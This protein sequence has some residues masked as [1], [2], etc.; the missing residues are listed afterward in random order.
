VPVT[1]KTR[2]G[3]D[4]RD[5]YEDLLRFAHLVAGAGARALIV[6]ARKAWLEG[7]DPKANRTVPPLEHHK[8]H[9]LKADL[10]GAD[11]PEV[12]VILN[13]GL[14]SPEEG[15][16]HLGPQPDGAPGVDGVMLG[17]A[18]YH[19]PYLLARVDA[20]YYGDR[21]HPPSR[22]AVAE[23][24]LAYVEEQ[25]RRGVP[26]RSVL[27]HLLGLYHGRPGA[28]RWRRILSGPRVDA[29]T[30]AQALEEVAGRRPAQPP[31]HGG[32]CA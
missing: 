24:M 27:R 9:A 12:E 1:V 22:E 18:A 6:H 29:G 31:T 20:L 15:L 17:R 26:A 14:G 19:D 13:G 32:M 8:V 30:L 23:A 10:A 4:H 2:V 25:A 28:R 7:L 3:V 5:R 21:R 16:A 11:L